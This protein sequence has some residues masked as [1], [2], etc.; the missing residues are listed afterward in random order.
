NAYDLILL[1]LMLPRRDGLVV[2]RNLRAAGVKSAIIVLTAKSQE[3]DKVVGLAVGADDY[4][5]KPYSRLE[6]MARV[7][8][9]LRRTRDGKPSDP[10]VWESGDI[11]VDFPRCHATISGQPIRLTATEFKIL[12]ALFESRGKV[13]TIDQLLQ[14]VWGADVFLTD[15]VIYTHVN[16]LR[17]KIEPDP[18]TPRLIVG[19]RGLGYRFDG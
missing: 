1:D 5:T 11:R 19:V 9:V 18:S 3:A 6:L 2:C 17:A 15:R 12:K 13:V 16:N 7:K 14:R 8:A 10:G 4:V